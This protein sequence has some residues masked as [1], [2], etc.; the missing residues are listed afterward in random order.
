[1]LIIKH[2]LSKIALIAL[3]CML[4]S[5]CAS[6][7]HGTRQKLALSSNPPGAT[8]SDGESSIQ[9]PGFLNLKR[10]QDYILTF[11]KPGYEVETVKVTHVIS[12]AVAGNLLAGGLIG[13]GVDAVSGAQW[14]LEPE[15]ISV[16][17]RPLHEAERFANNKNSAPQTLS[18]KLEELASLKEKNLITEAEYN[19][20]REVAIRAE[21]LA[22]AD[23]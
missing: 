9:T 4:F 23:K 16:N 6:I 7:V 18:D 21:P 12:G 10:N 1:M 13:W 5:G 15:T 14:R 2:L 11:T 22:L 20:M 3:A 19:S 17:L 8:V